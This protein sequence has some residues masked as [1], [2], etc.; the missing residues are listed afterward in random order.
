MPDKCK[1][2]LVSQTIWVLNILH[3]RLRFQLPQEL[4]TLK[5]WVE[6]FKHQIHRKTARSSTLIP[7]NCQTMVTKSSSSANS[8]ST[9]RT[10]SLLTNTVSLISRRSL[11]S[12]TY[13]FPRNA[14]TSNIPSPPKW[15]ITLFLFKQNSW[16]RCCLGESHASSTKKTSGL[17]CQASS[18][19][20]SLGFRETLWR[21]GSVL[22]FLDVSSWNQKQKV[23]CL[24][25]VQMEW[26]DGLSK[27]FLDLNLMKCAKW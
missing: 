4:P 7:R 17:W 27:W 15:Y 22:L 23:K 10:E 5:E 18:E 3:G 11:E 21:I 8:F 26:F 9:E 2:G 14:A 25:K 20:P 24:R 19:R 16:K 13:L 1:V 12:G 6:S